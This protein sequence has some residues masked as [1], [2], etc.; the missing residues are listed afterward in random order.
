MAFMNE[1][2]Y[3]T[4]VCKYLLLF[5]LRTLSMLRSRALVSCLLI[6]A[7]KECRANVKVLNPP[8]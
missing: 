6:D 4:R 7:F 5:S 1:W 2:G 3:A 8:L